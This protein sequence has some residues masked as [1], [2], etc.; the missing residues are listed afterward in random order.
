MPQI[1]NAHDPAGHEGPLPLTPPPWAAR[2]IREDG[3][4]THEV[5]SSVQ[6]S[7]RQS[8]NGWTAEPTDISLSTIDQHTDA[9]WIRATP[10]IQIEGGSYPLDSVRQLRDAIDALL[11]TLVS[12][13]REQLSAAS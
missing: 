8:R 13:D 9:G 12:H 6:P 5:I 4:V 7:V 10:T 11:E 2:S 3:G 1:D